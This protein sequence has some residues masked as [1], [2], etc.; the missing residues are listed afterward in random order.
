MELISNNARLPTSTKGNTAVMHHNV[1]LILPKLLFFFRY[2]NEE[3]FSSKTA[4]TAASTMQLLELG[5]SSDSNSKCDF[6]F[7]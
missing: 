7:S 2:F 3:M 1:E 5:N 4:Y 6:G